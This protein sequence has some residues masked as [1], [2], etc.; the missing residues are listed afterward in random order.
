MRS[1]AP[2]ATPVPRLAPLTKL[3][4]PAQ[5]GASAPNNKENAKRIDDSP[6]RVAASPMAAGGSKVLTPTGSSPCR[7]TGKGLMPPP[8]AE[9]ALDHAQLLISLGVGR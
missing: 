4:E 6:R 8:R 1:Q 7:R 9:F 3:A 5:S 2:V